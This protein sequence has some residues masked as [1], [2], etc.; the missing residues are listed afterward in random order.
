MFGA[1][2]HWR[3]ILE[4]GSK[5]GAAGCRRALGVSRI[6]VRVT[7]RQPRKFRQPARRLLQARHWQMSVLARTRQVCAVEKA[8]E[9]RGFAKERMPRT[10]MGA[11]RIGLHV[12]LARRHSRAHMSWRWAWRSMGAGRWRQL[13]GYFCAAQGTQMLPVHGICGT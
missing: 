2:W 1:L 11:R 10:P 7:G 4:Q 13:E 8:H 3:T 12:E 9:G 6:E 5:G